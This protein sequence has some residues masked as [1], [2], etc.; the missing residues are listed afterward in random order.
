MSPGPIH[1]KCSACETVLTGPG[2]GTSLP[3]WND[4]VT[5]GN[6]GAKVKGARFFDA[7]SDDPVALS[8]DSLYELLL[9]ASL[10]TCRQHPNNLMKFVT[11]PI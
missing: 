1:G 8:R 2:R 3:Y 11:T 5:L 6:M 9:S 4:L 7:T 10:E